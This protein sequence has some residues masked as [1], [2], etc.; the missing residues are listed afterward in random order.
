MRP[1]IEK[2]VKN[3]NTEWEFFGKQQRDLAYTLIKSGGKE[4]KAPYAARVG[5][6]WRGLGRNDLDGK[7]TDWPWSAAFISHIM[8]EAGAGSDFPYSAGHATYINHAIKAHLT[9]KANAAIVGRRINDYAPRVGDLIGCGRAGS[10]DLTYDT[11]KGWYTSHCDVVVDVRPGE[12][13]V[14]GGNVEN[15]VTKRTF[16]TDAQGHLADKRF[17][18]FVVIENRIDL[19]DTLVI[20][21]DGTV[22]TKSMVG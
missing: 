13:D 6:Y 8:R 7:D 5:V 3:A 10:A 16:G 14:I 18:W 12:V 19:E 11:A 2:L 22:L 1:F 4:D 21:L 9:H 20:A 17:P 15:S